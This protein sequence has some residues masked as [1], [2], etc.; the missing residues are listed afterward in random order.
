MET[1]KKNVKWKEK[2]GLC[3]KYV[4]DNLSIEKTN[5]ETARQS[6]DGTGNR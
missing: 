2:R 4:D 1:S 6:D 3:L 5:M